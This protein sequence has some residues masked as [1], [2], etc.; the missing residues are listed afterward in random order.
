MGAAIRRGARW[1]W[2]IFS[3]LLFGW[4]QATPAPER[5]RNLPGAATINNIEKQISQRQAGLREET[6]RK[7]L[8]HRDRYSTVTKFVTKIYVC[9]QK[10]QR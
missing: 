4:R 8:S 9:H 10:T 7:A 5:G 3:A 1:H 6:A 2:E